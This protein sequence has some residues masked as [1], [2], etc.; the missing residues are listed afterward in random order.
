MW[1]EIRTND[2]KKKITFSLLIV[3]IAL[4]SLFM[5]KYRFL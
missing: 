1:K 5:A 2:I 4:G 3:Q